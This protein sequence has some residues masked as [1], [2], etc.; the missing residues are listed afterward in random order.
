[1]CRRGYGR[2]ARGGGGEKGRSPALF[3]RGCNKCDI[4]QGREFDHCASR[5]PEGERGGDRIDDVVKIVVVPVATDPRRVGRI[6][7]C[8]GREPDEEAHNE[9][10]EEA[11]GSGHAS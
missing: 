1:M 7:E 5:S 8:N 9:Q 11:T 6:G 2:S 3:M 10:R 4:R